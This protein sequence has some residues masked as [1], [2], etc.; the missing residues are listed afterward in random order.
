[1]GSPA[2]ASPSRPVPTPEVCGYRRA[3]QPCKA[4]WKRVIGLAKRHTHVK[5]SEEDHDRKVTSKSITGQSLTGIE[6]QD[7]HGQRQPLWTWHNCGRSLSIQQVYVTPCI[8]S[9]WTSPFSHFLRTSNSQ[10]QLKAQPN[11]RR[12]LL[13]RKHLMVHNYISSRW[14]ILSRS[15]L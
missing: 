4:V 15:T 12:H 11:V 6:L 5:P 13:D 1:M 8:S 10:N 9:S 3:W 14:S 7:K 2:K